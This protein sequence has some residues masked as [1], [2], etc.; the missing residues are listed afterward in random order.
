ME[1]NV[2]RWVLLTG[3]TGYVGGRLLSKLEQRGVRVRCLTRR[4]EA[5]RGR[6][7]STTEAVAG[8]VRGATGEIR[9]N[10]FLAE[11]GVMSRRKAD[12]LIR[13]GVVRVNGTVITEL[14][15]KVNA[16]RDA[17]SVRGTPVEI[18]TQLVR[19]VRRAAES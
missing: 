16:S 3:A 18:Q 5:L 11:A 6:V 10:K 9:L 8:D 14:G 13:S 17:V 12:E 15:V 7:G 19:S 1:Q 2:G 4:P